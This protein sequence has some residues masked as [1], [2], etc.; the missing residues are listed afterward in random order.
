MLC[1]KV[2]NEGMKIVLIHGQNHKGSTWNVAKILIDKFPQTKVLEEFFLPKDL[3]HFCLG[4]YSCIEDETKCPYWNEK[5]RIAIA[6]KAADVLI[7]TTPTYCMMP[8]APM[9][10]FLDLFFTNWLVHKPKEE[11]FHKQAIVLSTSAGAGAGKAAKLLANNLIHWGIPSVKVYGIA[12]NAM[13]WDMV[14][15]KK[16]KKIDKDMKRL[17]STVKD[18]VRIGVKIR[19]LFR[20]CAGM[21]RANWGASKSEKEYWISKGWLNGVKPWK[22]GKQNS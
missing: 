20:F 7:F 16:K 22:N 13:N 11:M 19:F 14:P 5:R 18:K 17:A 8:S 4:C 2:I 3:N 6:M 10:S 15:E 1:D 21:Q 12:V 9:K